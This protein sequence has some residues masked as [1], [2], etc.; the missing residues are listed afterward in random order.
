MEK[1][2]HQGRLLGI[3]VSSFADGVNPITDPDAATQILTLK[4]P[5]GAK[6]TPHRHEPM[7]RITT[8][9]QEC[10]VVYKG[11]IQIDLY[12]DEVQPVATVVVRTGQAFI[13]LQGGHTVT[14]LE[15]A[16]FFEIK[17][18]PFKADRVSIE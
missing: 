7:E 18:G 14:I 9:L 4:C 6:I 10:L 2:L 3:H 1:I 12:G 13:T 16:E 15:D 11:A 17:N 5:A 8:Q